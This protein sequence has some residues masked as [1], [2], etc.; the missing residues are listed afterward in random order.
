[1][2]KKRKAR[3]R[4]VKA[5]II[6]VEKE[7]WKDKAP[8]K[9]FFAIFN[10]SGLAIDGFASLLV[11]ILIAGMFLTVPWLWWVTLSAEFSLGNIFYC[12]FIALVMWVVGGFCIEEFEGLKSLVYIIFIAFVGFIIY[13]WYDYYEYTKCVD[14]FRKRPLTFDKIEF[15]RCGMI[16]ENKA[17]GKSENQI[18]QEM[19][20]K[21]FKND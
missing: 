12:I 6:P 3:R 18:R 15:I 20:Y 8:F 4:K 11:W 21:Y 16:D 5:E 9:Y 17:Y 13:S 10:L 1:M 19:V 2:V 14:K 7:T